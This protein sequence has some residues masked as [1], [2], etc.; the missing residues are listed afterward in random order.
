M[1]SNITIHLFKL[2]L[3]EVDVEVDNQKIDRLQYAIFFGRFLLKK[4]IQI[5]VLLCHEVFFFEKK[6]NINLTSF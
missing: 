1:L 5:L 4:K 3:I 2:I 6:N